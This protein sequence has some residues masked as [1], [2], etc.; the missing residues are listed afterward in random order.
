MPNHQFRDDDVD[1]DNETVIVNGERLT[2]ADADT[3]MADEL[4]GRKRI[5][6]RKSLSGEGHSPVVNVRVSAETRAAL[7]DK[8]ASTGDKLSTVSR[9]ALDYTV[10]YFICWEQQFDGAGLEVVRIDKPLT[11]EQAQAQFDG[12]KTTAQALRARTLQIRRGRDEVV[13]EWIP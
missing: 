10:S 7:A 3:T 12:W 8:V 13:Q 2:E 9:E 11:L 4:S 5:P 1:L 6:G